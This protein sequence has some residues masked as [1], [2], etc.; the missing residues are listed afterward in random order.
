[1]MNVLVNENHFQF[2]YHFIFQEAVE[3]LM[4][5]GLYAKDARPL[6]EVTDG[7]STHTCVTTFLTFSID[8]ISHCNPIPR[9]SHFLRENVW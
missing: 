3:Y 5:S 6:F 8:N 4:P 7:S 2:S 1:M 9:S